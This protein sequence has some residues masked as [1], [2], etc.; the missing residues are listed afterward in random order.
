MACQLLWDTFQPGRTCLLGRPQLLASQAWGALRGH[1]QG[2]QPPVGCRKRGAMWPGSCQLWSHTASRGGGA[3]WTPARRSDAAD[4][5]GAGHRLVHRLPVPHPGVVPGVPGGEGRERP[6]RHLRRRALVG[7]GES[8]PGLGVLGAGA[9]TGHVLPR[10]P[11]STPRCAPDSQGLDWRWLGSLGPGTSPGTTCW[12]LGAM[13]PRLAGGRCSGWCVGGEGPSLGGPARPVSSSSSLPPSLPVAH[14][15]ATPWE[16]RTGSAACHIQGQ[17]VCE[18]ETQPW[19]PPGPCSRP[20]RLSWP[21]LAS[22]PPRQ[23]TAPPMP[24][25]PLPTCFSSQ[26]CPLSVPPVP[27]GC[28]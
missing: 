3:G 24:P 5:P 21:E 15:C 28:G 4:S 8:Q 14:L 11:S 13:V 6:L 16:G 22:R 9:V 25:R 1:T 2:N 19:R 12:P 18:R 17:K 7:P 26:H 23:P 27:P 20:L 10:G